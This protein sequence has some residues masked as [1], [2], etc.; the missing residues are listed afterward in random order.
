ML[1]QNVKYTSD[2]IF[3]RH[4]AVQRVWNISAIIYVAYM[5]KL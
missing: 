2:F 1:C 5:L 3:E 4:F